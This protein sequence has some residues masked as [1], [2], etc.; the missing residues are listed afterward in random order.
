MW[1][2]TGV[3]T[4]DI[5]DL[6]ADCDAWGHS[7]LL[8]SVTVPKLGSL[9]L[10]VPSTSFPLSSY[11]PPNIEKGRI[12]LSANVPQTNISQ[13][14]EGNCKMRGDSSL[15]IE[16]TGLRKDFP[17]FVSASDPES[18]CPCHVSLR[19]TVVSRQP[20]LNYRIPQ[21]PSSPMVGG[22]LVTGNS[23]SPRGD[24]C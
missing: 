21:I 3:L 1:K 22:S 10:P 13:E 7:S 8:F 2:L 9:S 5:W 19:Q 4:G 16:V 20:C 6:I 18:H 17:V 24:N 15:F 12:S 23:R 11:L 14:V